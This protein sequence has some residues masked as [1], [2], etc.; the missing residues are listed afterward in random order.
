MGKLN[1]LPNVSSTPCLRGTV[2][3]FAQDLSCSRTEFTEGDPAAEK[4]LVSAWAQ[5]GAE[6]EGGSSS[7]EQGEGDGSGRL[8]AVPGHGVT[9]QAG[10]AGSS[11]KPRAQRLSRDHLAF[12]THQA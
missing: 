12:C 8:R 11:C 6:P 9:C 10:L 1:P 4:G 7:K 2:D 3:A 5:P